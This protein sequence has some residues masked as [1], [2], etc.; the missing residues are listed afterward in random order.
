[1]SQRIADG[2]GVKNGYPCQ[3]EWPEDCH[4]QC[5]D[6]FLHK[7]LYA[8]AFFEAFPKNP[9]TFLRG[10]GAT[11]KEAEENTWNK[12]Q[13]IVN[14][15][16]HDYVRQSDDRTGICK[17]CNLRVHN[18]FIPDN[19]CA[20]CGKKHVYLHI[21]EKENKKFFCMEHYAEKILNPNFDLSEYNIRE[22]KI[23]QYM[24]YLKEEATFYKK[25]LEMVGFDDSKND[26]LVALSLEKEYRDK[27]YAWMKNFLSECCEKWNE[28]HFGDINKPI[29]LLAFII[30]TDKF[31]SVFSLEPKLGEDI[32][33]L[34][35]LSMIK[36]QS[37]ESLMQSCFE[38]SLDFI[39][40]NNLLKSDEDE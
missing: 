11:L 30:F 16:K 39:E 5:G 21:G 35:L 10:E 29:K 24:G 38:R 33:Y 7:G 4:V 37:D 26:Y 6:A 22:N 2:S 8:P 25:Y 13:A 14:C 9:S 1:M 31:R 15:P 23:Q 18:Y 32:M 36:E 12:Y 34:A 40:K 3:K 28:K 20:V 19:S 27:L 17:H